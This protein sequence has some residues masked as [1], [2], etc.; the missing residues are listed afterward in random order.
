VRLHQLDR[1][2]AS[3]HGVVTLQACLDAGL[4]ERTWYRALGS[5]EL[6]VMHRGVARVP[7]TVRTRWQRISAAVLAVGP[8]ALASHRSA[9]E[10]WGV[11][12][13]ADEV[14]DV[15]LPARRRRSSSLL[16][17]VLVHRPR[18]QRDLRPS[19]RSNVLCTNILRTLCDLGA[20]DPAGVNA[21]VGFVLN[22]GLASAA[23]LDA[24]LCSHSR[25]GRHG[26]VAFRTA[27]IDWT[28]DGRVRDSELEK[29]MTELVRRFRLPPVEF[30][31]ILVGYEVDFR[32]VGTP[33]VLECDGFEV[34]GRRE[35]FESDRRRD[36]ELAAAG[37]IVVRFTWRA[38][39]KRPQ[40][41]AT[42]IRTAV[43]RWRPH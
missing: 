6:E 34:H 13:P 8:G 25:Q 38:L 1:F 4:S 10:L 41:V 32:V 12:R 11:E 30:H 9:A 37:Y 20:V 19:R 33:I 3:H 2:A 35:C 5:G 15:I 29:R 24:A 23:A 27:F 17:G 31:P 14:V 26:I 22:S 21:A 36:A 42:I 43:E 18:D 40:W 7:G 28:I 16:D 39:S